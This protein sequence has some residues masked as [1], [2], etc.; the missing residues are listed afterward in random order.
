[1][2]KDD[3][4][5]LSDKDKIKVLAQT[6]VDVAGDDSAHEIQDNTGWDM[7]MCEKIVKVTNIA[8]HVVGDI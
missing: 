2:T 1:M 5:A 6:L 3:F 8:R 4:N 7:A